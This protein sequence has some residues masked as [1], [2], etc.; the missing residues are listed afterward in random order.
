MI[1]YWSPDYDT[2]VGGVK[3]LYHDVDVLNANGIEAA[4]L[5][6]KRGFRC[7]WFENNTRVA[8]MGRTKL[9][10]DDF[11][12]IPEV[13]GSL[14][15]HPEHR[16]KAA[17]VSF[18]QR[19]V[20]RC[21]LIVDPGGATLMPFIDG[22]SE[23]DHRRSLWKGYRFSFRSKDNDFWPAHVRKTGQDL[24]GVLAFRLPCG[25][26]LEPGA[27]FLPLRPVALIVMMGG[28]AAF[29]HFMHGLGPYLNFNAPDFRADDACMKALIIVMDFG[30]G[31]VVFHLTMN[32][33]KL[34]MN[35]PHDRLTVPD[36]PHDDPESNEVL[37]LIQFKT[38]FPNL[39]IDPIEM[40]DSSRGPSFN[41]VFR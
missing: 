28:D 14:Y 30:G 32:R 21:G 24:F 38:P 3:I 33:R 19:R 7:T 17:R 35:Q 31:D 12:V 11:L 27:P 13:Y 16:P 9:T 2:P 40:F 1:Y 22:V 6:R 34:F 8:Y 39:V 25:D 5:H 36:I 41:T 4:V 23:V 20:E 29:R 15:A 18:L 37:H 26:L 10:C